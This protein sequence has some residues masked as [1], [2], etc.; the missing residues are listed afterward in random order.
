M[1]LT[2]VLLRQGKTRGSDK[3]ILFGGFA[4]AWLRG[5]WAA[6][7]VFQISNDFAGTILHLSWFDD[8]IRYDDINDMIRYDNLSKY[9]YLY[10]LKVDRL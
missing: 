2:E 6:V 7:V 5:K 4:A 3:N 1:I 10:L 8:V 9:I